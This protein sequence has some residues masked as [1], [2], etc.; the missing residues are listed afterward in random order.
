MQPYRRPMR[1]PGPARGL[2]LDSL[3][4]SRNAGNDR[5]KLHLRF[6]IIFC[7]Y[8]KIVKK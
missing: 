2:F 3:V 8:Y 7:K 1:E 4:I 5:F 6:L